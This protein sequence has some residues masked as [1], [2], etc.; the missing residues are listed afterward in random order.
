MWGRTLKARENIVLGIL[1]SDAQ[2]FELNSEFHYD[3]CAFCM[4]FITV[5]I[6]F[7]CIFELTFSFPLRCGYFILLSKYCKLTNKFT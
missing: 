2:L 1:Q 5:C 7:F 4:Y 6:N 3:L